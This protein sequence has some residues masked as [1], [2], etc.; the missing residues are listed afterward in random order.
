MFRILKN[1]FIF[2]TTFLLV[3]GAVDFYMKYAGVVRTSPHQYVA[4]KGIPRFQK[5]DEHDLFQ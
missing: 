5:S 1:I 4:G 2:C 3:I